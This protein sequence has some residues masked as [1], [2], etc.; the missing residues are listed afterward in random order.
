MK[1]ISRF[2]YG[3]TR[4][5]LVRVAWKKKL[6]SKLFSDNKYHGKKQALKAAIE[7]RNKFEWMLGKPRTERTVQALGRR[8]NHPGVVL[9]RD[10]RYFI[11][12]WP[13]KTPGTLGRSYIMV[14]AYPSL[15]KAFTAAMFLRKQ[16]EKEIYGQELKG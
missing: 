13:G 14:D 15:N 9:S 8:G 7:Y 6:H 11:V 5:W 4:G 12:T 16:K 1:S 10:K 3:R 2:D